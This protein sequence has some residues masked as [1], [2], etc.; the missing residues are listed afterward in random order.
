MKAYVW[1]VIA[2]F[3]NGASLTLI[4]ILSDIPIE[5]RSALTW[6]SVISFVI[7]LIAGLISAD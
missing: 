7:G 4:G 2:A 6:Q 3:L 5:L 1:V